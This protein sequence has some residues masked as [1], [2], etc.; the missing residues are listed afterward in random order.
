MALYI[1]NGIISEYTARLTSW[2]S[3]AEELKPHFVMRKILSEGMERGEIPR[4]EV[5]FWITIY[6]GVMLQPLAQYPVLGCFS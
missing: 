5:Y 1:F 4:Q 3:L 6:S 2:D